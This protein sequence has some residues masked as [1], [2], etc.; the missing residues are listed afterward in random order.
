M[1]QIVRQKADVSR[2]E[3]FSDVVRILATCRHELRQARERIDARISE[4]RDLRLWLIPEDGIPAPTLA[5]HHAFQ[6][7]TAT[8]SFLAQ[9]CVDADGSEPVD[10]EGLLMNSCRHSVTLARLEC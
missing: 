1:N 5:G 2:C 6:K 3:A 7:K 10:H 8:T 9:R 4:E